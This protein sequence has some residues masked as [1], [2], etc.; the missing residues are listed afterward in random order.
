MPIHLGA[1]SSTWS[2]FEQF[3]SLQNKVI[4]ELNSVTDNPLI[5]P[6][7]SKS[8]E[9]DVI[10]QGNFHGEILALT[11]DN[12]SLALFEIGSISER[13]MDQILDPARSGLPAFLA[14]NSGLE[15]GLMIVQ[16]VAGAS[17]AEMRG[18]ANPGLHSQLQ[19][20]QVKKIRVNGSN[21]LFQSTKD[22]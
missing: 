10:S 21:S 17:L 7:L 20:L 5:F 2:G 18:H 13:R 9:Y 16:Y 11:A 19:P 14:E 1:P 15:S 6:S 22:D 8:G 4:I 3:L 12:M